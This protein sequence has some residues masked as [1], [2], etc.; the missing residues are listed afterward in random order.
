M[1]E[2]EEEVVEEGEGEG[3]DGSKWGC[4]GCEDWWWCWLKVWAYWGWMLELEL[5]EE[6]C[7]WPFTMS[8]G[9]AGAKR[10]GVAR[11][12]SLPTRSGTWRERRVRFA[13]RPDAAGAGGSRTVGDG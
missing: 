7:A 11:R 8:V 3:S 4:E 13:G 5:V 10:G 1:E 12:T 9:G 2:E 6:G